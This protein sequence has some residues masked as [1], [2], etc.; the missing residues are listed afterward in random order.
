MTNITKI[1]KIFFLLTFFSSS[2]IGV[3]IAEECHRGTLDVGYCDRNMDQVA[4]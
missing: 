3:S 1:L 2:W 4:F